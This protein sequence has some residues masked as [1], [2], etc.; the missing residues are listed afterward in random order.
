MT[1]ETAALLKAKDVRE[2]WHSVLSTQAGRLAVWSILEECH[3]FA[4]T[5]HGHPLDGLR[6]GMR[7]IGLRILN[8]RVF[9]HDVR[10]FATMQIEHAELMQRIEREA[11]RATK[12]D[13]DDD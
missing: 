3:L 6:A 11:E 13:Q 7:E 10:T 2:A 5:H 12:E 8:D 9:P 1:Q 4:Q